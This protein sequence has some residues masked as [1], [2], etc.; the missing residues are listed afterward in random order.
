MASYTIEQHVQMI[1]LYYQNECLLVKILCDSPSK[2]TLQRLVAKFKTTGSI[3]N[4]PTPIRQR[5]AR[6]AENIAAVRVSVQ[7]NPIQ[8]NPRRTQ[9]H[10][11]SQ[12][13][14]W[15]I[16]RRDL[17]LHPYKI[18]LTQELKSLAME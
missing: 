11:F 16:L 17:G 6:S 10:G 4:L 18:H 15:Q 3:N 9:E 13:S 7:E 1:K 5:N 2:S 8:S 12:T 14:T